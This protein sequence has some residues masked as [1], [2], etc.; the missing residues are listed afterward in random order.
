MEASVEHAGVRVYLFCLR[1]ILSQYRRIAGSKAKH[2]P[3]ND[4][5]DVYF[6]V[7]LKAAKSCEMVRER[8]QAQNGTDS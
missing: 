8:K 4:G 6:M 3:I 7:T 2:R 5:G 1:N